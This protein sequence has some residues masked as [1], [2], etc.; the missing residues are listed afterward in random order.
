[1]QE[2]DEKPLL[3]HLVEVQISKA[4]NWIY[5]LS[6][7][8]EIANDIKKDVELEERFA[9]DDPKIRLTNEQF[10]KSALNIISLVN[11]IEANSG[12]TPVA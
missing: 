4:P 12:L 1:M 5:W 3:E 8:Q 10:E 9:Y 2:D 11:T 6:T 7:S